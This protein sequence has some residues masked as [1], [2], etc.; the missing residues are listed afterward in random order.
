MD[1]TRRLLRGELTLLSDFPKELDSFAAFSVTA[2]T[3]GP[4]G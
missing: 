1:I 3:D 2:K 4:L